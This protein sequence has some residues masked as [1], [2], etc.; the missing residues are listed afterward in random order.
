MPKY[1]AM[2]DRFETYTFICMK[3]FVTLFSKTHGVKVELAR[4]PHCW[5]PVAVFENDEDEV[6]HG[7]TLR[8][9]LKQLY[10][11]LELYRPYEG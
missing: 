1:L 8:E 6:R 5:L 2:S 4:E 7:R 11:G 3:Q 10:E 9:N